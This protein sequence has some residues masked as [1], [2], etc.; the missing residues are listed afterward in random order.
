[1][2]QG[3]ETSRWHLKSAPCGGQEENPWASAQ[4]PKP[5]PRSRDPRRIEPQG[6]WSAVPGVPT[7]QRW[8]RAGTPRADSP[9]QSAD[10]RGTQEQQ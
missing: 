9:P 4:G 3:L 1:M 5:L 7:L 10:V 8:G 6:S 2:C